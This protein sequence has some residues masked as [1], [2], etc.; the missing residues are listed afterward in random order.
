MTVNWSNY[1]GGDF[2][3]Q[4]KF[5]AVGDSI[6]GT[7]TD[8]REHDFGDGNQPILELTTDDGDEFSVI[9]SQRNLQ[10]R[11]AEV[12]PASGDRIAIKFTGEGQPSKPGYNPPKLFEVAHKRG[13]APEAP[14][15]E[16]APAAAGPS[17]DD[18]L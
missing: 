17:A 2:P 1:A 18:L 3:A 14:A 13:D 8:V 5:Q 7:I 10:V 16:P 4:F 15:P 6:A 11:L 12:R 9:A